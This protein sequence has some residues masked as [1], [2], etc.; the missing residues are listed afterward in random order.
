MSFQQPL[1]IDNDRAKDMWE[2]LLAVAE[3][4]GGDWPKRAREACQALAHESETETTEADVKLL[5][6]LADIRDIF[7]KEPEPDPLDIA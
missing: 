4:A 2:Q 5:A 1:A 3:V 7:A 6:L